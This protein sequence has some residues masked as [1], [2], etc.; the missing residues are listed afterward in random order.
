MELTQTQ[1]LLLSSTWTWSKA[2]MHLFSNSNLPTICFREPKQ[3]Y[4]K[5]CFRSS[6]ST[7]QLSKENDCFKT[8]IIS[9]FSN[10]N[11]FLFEVTVS[12]TALTS[13]LEIQESIS[14][15][16]RKYSQPFLPK[17]H[18]FRTLH[19]TT[20][21]QMQFHLEVLK[22]WILGEHQLLSSKTWMSQTVHLI[23]PTPWSKLKSLLIED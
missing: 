9:I 22:I 16:L 20:L 23:L 17:N 6:N 21:R 2:A 14:F 19:L 8:P 5:E 15:I 13:T 11:D 3:L 4:L 18:L 12:L 1:Y 10:Q 7:T